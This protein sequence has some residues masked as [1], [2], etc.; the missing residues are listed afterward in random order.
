MALE[1]EQRHV[2][3]LADLGAAA[4]NRTRTQASDKIWTAEDLL[5]LKYRL[6]RPIMVNTEE[7]TDHGADCDAGS[8]KAALKG[9][10]PEFSG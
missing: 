2:W 9:E 1:A 8:L 4:R 10:L 7:F 3:Y 5:R 6:P